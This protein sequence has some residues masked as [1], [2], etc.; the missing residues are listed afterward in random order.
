ML[1]YFAGPSFNQAEKEFNKKLVR[2]IEVL[3]VEVFLPQRDGAERNKPPFDKMPPDE[4]RKAIFKLDRDKIS[5]ADIFLFVLD[6]RVPDEGAALELGMAY[7]D[8]YSRNGKKLIVGL[9][10]DSRT[11]FA[12]TKLNPML[13]GALDIVAGSEYELID[14]LKSYV[15]TARNIK[16]TQE[17]ITKQIS[18]SNNQ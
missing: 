16:K 10:T 1:L 3:G 5:A 11:T 2:K 6:G 13:K 7:A 8:K 14:C 12:N 15:F 18:T 17:T 9:M 4:R